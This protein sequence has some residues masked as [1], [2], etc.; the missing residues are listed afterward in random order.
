MFF[1]FLFN[2]F[3]FLNV[4]SAEE[5]AVSQESSGLN[6]SKPHLFLQ[7]V[8][9]PEM[10]PAWGE[11]TGFP[12]MAVW[13]E[14]KV[15]KVRE[16][17][18]LYG[19]APVQRFFFLTVHDD[20]VLPVWSGGETEKKDDGDFSAR[21][22]V[23]E[24]ITD[25]GAEPGAEPAAFAKNYSIFWNVP[26]EF[27]NKEL[28]IYIEANA[29]EDFNGFYK[30]GFFISPRYQRLNGQPSLI[31]RAALTA[32]AFPVTGLS[33]VPAGRGDWKGKTGKIFQDTDSITTASRILIRAEASYFL[34]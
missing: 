24:G 12:Y 7:I 13:V 22:F 18:F 27:I 31:W 9:N 11:D 29:P 19:P 16:T 6:L 26:D 1:L 32:G 20:F 33:F 15:S 4:L 5:A 28:T 23:V 34:E 10:Y 30:K 3:I 8:L 2:S 17:L 14:E 25:S 21:S